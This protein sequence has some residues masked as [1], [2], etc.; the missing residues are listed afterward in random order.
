MEI[1]RPPS[2]QP[3]PKNAKKVFKGIIFDVYQ[4]EQEMFDGTRAIFEKLKRPDTVVVFPVLDDGKILLTRQEQPGKQPFIGATGGRVDEGED[5]LTAA[6]REL[7]EESGYV[8]DELIL[9]DAQ[10]PIGKIEWAVYTF[11]AKGLKKVS[12]MNLDSGEKIELYPVTF[13]EMI[14]LAMKKD[15]YEKEIVE[16]IYE[17]KLDP[18]KYEELKKLFAPRQ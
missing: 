1:K 18:K 8:A 10:Q 4:W 3:I 7:L 9:W 13:E 11:V 14:N 17:A 6:R 15:F 12:D 2:N 5:I 16:K